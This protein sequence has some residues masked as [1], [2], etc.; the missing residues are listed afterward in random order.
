MQ[1]D[2]IVVYP[3]YSADSIGKIKEQKRRTHQQQ[4]KDSKKK[5]VEYQCQIEELQKQLNQADMELQVVQGE[6]ERAKRIQDEEVRRLKREEEAALRMQGAQRIIGDDILRGQVPLKGSAANTI[7]AG[8]LPGS[9]GV[10][11]NGNFEDYE[12]QLSD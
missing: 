7:D 9:D 10:S 5:Q 6:Y 3:D 11:G 12:K 1:G 8:R 2:S 4:I